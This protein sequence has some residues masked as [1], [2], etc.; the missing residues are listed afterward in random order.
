VK[1]FPSVGQTNC[2]ICPSWMHEWKNYFYESKHW[3]NGYFRSLQTF[4]LWVNKPF[5]LITIHNLVIALVSNGLT[6]ALLLAYSCNKLKH[7]HM[8]VQDVNIQR[9]WNL[10]QLRFHILWFIIMFIV[11]P[12]W[13]E[14]KESTLGCIY[15][16]EYIMPKSFINLQYWKCIFNSLTNMSIVIE[17]WSFTCSMDVINT[18]FHIGWLPSTIKL[19]M[20]AW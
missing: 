11:T 5:L 19:T 8:Q 20:W 18:W 17:Q 15:Y 9:F 1:L 13:K 10:Q 4:N 3:N 16:C 12:R 2:A 14:K 7:A 6:I